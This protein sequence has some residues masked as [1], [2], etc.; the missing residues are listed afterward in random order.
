MWQLVK[1]LSR[2]RSRGQPQVGTHPCL[3]QLAVLSLVSLITTSLVLW[4]FDEIKLRLQTR[5]RNAHKS[6]LQ[7]VACK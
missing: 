1:W 2:A 3:L 7:N 6:E 4:P 5:R